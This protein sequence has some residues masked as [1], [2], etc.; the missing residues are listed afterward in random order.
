[1]RDGCGFPSVTHP[2]RT[3]FTITNAGIG[4]ESEMRPLNSLFVISSNMGIY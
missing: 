2:R 3:Y 4:K 1:M